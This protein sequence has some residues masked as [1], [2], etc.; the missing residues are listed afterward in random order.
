MLK[1]LTRFDRCDGLI[2]CLEEIRDLA[3]HD[4]FGGLHQRRHVQKITSC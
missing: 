2:C 3:T 1:G 4:I